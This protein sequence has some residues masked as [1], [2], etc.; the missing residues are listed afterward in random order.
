MK[1]EIIW[2]KSRDKCHLLR[3]EELEVKH[4]DYESDRYSL[5]IEMPILKSLCETKLSNIESRNRSSAE[6]EEIKTM[7]ICFS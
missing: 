4:E 6:T 2:L 5:C 7:V 3:I 1:L